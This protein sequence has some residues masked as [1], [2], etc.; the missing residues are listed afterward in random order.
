MQL[1]ALSHIETVQGVF[2]VIVF[3]LC[4]GPS[5]N[6]LCLQALIISGIEY[7][8]PCLHYHLSLSRLP[9][10]PANVLTLTLESTPLLQGEK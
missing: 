7:Q 3:S 2:L 6:S 4:L 8:G 9:L 10:C 5:G 1:Y